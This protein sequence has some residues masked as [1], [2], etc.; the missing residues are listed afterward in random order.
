MKRIALVVL[1]IF[2]LLCGCKKE[3]A[4]DF[5]TSLSETCDEVVSTATGK[6]GAYYEIVANYKGDVIEVGIIKDYQWLLEPTADMPFVTAEN[7][8]TGKEPEVGDV[9]YLGQGCFVSEKQPTDGFEYIYIFYNVETGLSY[10]TASWPEDRRSLNFSMFESEQEDEVIV[11]DYYEWTYD[12]DC[13]YKNV[14][15]VLNKTNMTTY[16]VHIFNDDTLSCR[17]SISEGLFCVDN[18]VFK[19]VAGELELVEYNYYFY[20]LNGKMVID[21]SNYDIDYQELRFI[22]GKCTFDINKE[23]DGEYTVTINKAGKIIET[24][25]K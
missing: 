16:E 6:N 25:K 19:E 7:M 2:L 5:S 22:N 1:S 21:L 10:S 23:F 11:G 15:V 13:F 24:T 3:Q 4:E 8:I 14:F 17:T 18:A 9:T 12:S 20:D